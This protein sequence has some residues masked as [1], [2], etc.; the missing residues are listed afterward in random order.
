MQRFVNGNMFP[1]LATEQLINDSDRANGLRNSGELS[2]ALIEQGI[3]DY[4]FRSPE[5]LAMPV[6]VIAG[7]R[8]LQAAI[9]PQRILASRLRNGRLSA[10]TGNGHFMWAEDPER[11]ARETAAFLAGR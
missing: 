7:D 10:W 4:R 8:D 1:D 11:F 3:L 6:L 2:S 5:R 9:E